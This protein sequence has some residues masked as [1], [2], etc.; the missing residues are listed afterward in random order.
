MEGN[1]EEWTR[2]GISLIVEYV[3]NLRRWSMQGLQQRKAC[4]LTAK[5]PQTLEYI[6]R[7]TTENALPNPLLRARVSSTIIKK[8]II[9]NDVFH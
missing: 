8:A 1:T 5:F 6:H 4:N 9:G 7:R 3:P 2:T